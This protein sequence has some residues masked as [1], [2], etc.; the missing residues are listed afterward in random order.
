[1]ILSLAELP[2]SE[3]RAIVIPF[4]IRAVQSL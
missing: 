3:T 2:V 1:V 4:A